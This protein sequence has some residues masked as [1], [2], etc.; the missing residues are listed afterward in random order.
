MLHPIVSKI[1]HELPDVHFVSFDVEE[2]INTATELGIR[3]IPQMFIYKSG[4]IVS[5]K[6]G[7]SDYATVLAWIKDNI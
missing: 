1:S 6:P 5:Q 3:N 4:K 7:A 2:A